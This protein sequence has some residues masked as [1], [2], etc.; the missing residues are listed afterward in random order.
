M[1]SDIFLYWIS[2]T[3][4]NRLKSNINSEV[5]SVK[6]KGTGFSLSLKS[7]QLGCQSRRL[8]NQKYCRQFEAFTPSLDPLSHKSRQLRPQNSHFL[9][10]CRHLMRTLR[11]H[12]RNHT[13]IRKERGKF[14]QW[15]GLPFTYHS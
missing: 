1:L 15:C 11:G 4:L 2:F 8:G 5:S 6:S 10:G 13:A 9:A 12:K 7:R 14:P 3:L